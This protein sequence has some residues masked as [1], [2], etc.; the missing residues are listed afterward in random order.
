MWIT[1]EHRLGNP[2][3]NHLLSRVGAI[4]KAYMHPAGA[5]DNI[6]W[7]P[8]GDHVNS[9]GTPGRRHV[10]NHCTLPIQTVR[11]LIG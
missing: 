11:N 10:G 4:G 5:H 2:V 3:D 7:M 6:I 1:R 9:F 8:T